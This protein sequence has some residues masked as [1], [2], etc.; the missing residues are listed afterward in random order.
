MFNSTRLF[1]RIFSVTKFQATLLSIR[2]KLNSSSIL[3][4]FSKFLINSIEE[5]KFFS[6]TASF[7]FLNPRQINVHVRFK[8]FSKREI[9]KT[10]K[11]DLILLRFNFNK[12]RK[13][14]KIFQFQCKDSKNKKYYLFQT[15]LIRINVESI[16]L[17][18]TSCTP[19]K[20]LFSTFKRF[21]LYCV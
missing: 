1:A 8:S 15:Y 17:F 19:R 6:L 16:P 18:Q 14:V 20:N 11:F 3:S 12:D 13:L 2:Y 10:E 5:V 4:Q 9:F 21:F 7:S